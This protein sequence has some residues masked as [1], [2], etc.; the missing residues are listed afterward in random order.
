VSWGPYY[1]R[2]QKLIPLRVG[3]VL[4]NDLLGLIVLIAQVVYQLTLHVKGMGVVSIVGIPKF[5][6]RDIGLTV[7]SSLP[8]HPCAPIYH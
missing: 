4:S 6:W 3:H 1:R 2:V 5:R 8:K 7:L